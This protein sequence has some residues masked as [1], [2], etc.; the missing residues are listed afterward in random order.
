MQLLSFGLVA[1]SL[2]AQGKL[3]RGPMPAADAAGSASVAT[4]SATAVATGTATASSTMT[5]GLTP[6]SAAAG[7][8]RELLT[9]A[10][11][12]VVF[13]P[14][15]QDAWLLAS[16][17]PRP[18]KV[19]QATQPE[20]PPAQPK[21][22]SNKRR[23]TVL[24]IDI[25]SRKAEPVLALEQSADAALLL[26][27]DPVVGISVLGFVGPNRACLEGKA[28][29]VQVRF[30]DKKAA[31]IKIQ[32]NYSLTLSPKGAMIIDRE[33]DSIVTFDQETLQSRALRKLP[34]AER[35]LAFDGVKQ[36]ITW[37][38]TADF[39]GIKFY[40]GA[41]DANPR[42]ISVKAGDKLVQDGEQFAVVQRDLVNNSLQ[43]LELNGETSS[44][45]AR[46][47]SLRLPAQQSV[48]VAGLQLR[49]AKKIAIVFGMNDFAKRQW[50]QAF[51]FDL[52]QREPVASVRPLAQQY[53]GAA[54]LDARGRYAV[55]EIRDLETNYTSGIRL[56]D[57][58]T[59]ELIEVQLPALR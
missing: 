25:K 9:P 38:D 41:K 55:F 22:P 20:S 34:Q 26:Q 13:G 42:Q 36:L 7:C 56:Y 33:R 52:K 54:A 17:A 2:I 15:G 51:V 58:I 45:P 28:S 46:P 31:P 21:Q 4:A 19:K 53:V 5:G 23:Y 14:D 49:L 8:F 40:A 32:G 11:G 48:A 39:R 37:A 47:Y 43:L 1:V 44:E 18:S 30:A 24:R 29:I 35:A 50:R 12:A 10:A 57:A 3:P 16:A 59:R 6:A 27:G